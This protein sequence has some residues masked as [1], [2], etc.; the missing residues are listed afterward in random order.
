[1]SN[2]ITYGMDILISYFIEEVR[3]FKELIFVYTD[4]NNPINNL[5]LT[6]TEKGKKNWPN[7]EPE[8]SNYIKNDPINY[9][10]MDYMKNMNIMFANII[11]NFDKILNN[12]MAD[13]IRDYLKT[14]RVPYLISLIGYLCLCSA[15]FLFIWLPFVNNLNSIIYKTKKMLSIIPK[16]VLMSIGNIEKLL[17]IN[18]NKVKNQK[19]IKFRK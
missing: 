6:G 19:N 18:K 8:L 5:T 3:F 2:S 4:F 7:K 10:N 15:L 1:M 9:F 11:L 13:S 14:I 17:D 12:L 16:E